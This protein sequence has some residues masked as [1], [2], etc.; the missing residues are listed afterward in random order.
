MGWARSSSGSLEDD[1]VAAM[2][3]L[4]EYSETSPVMERSTMR[5]GD[6]RGGALGTLTA[7][8]NWTVFFCLECALV[9]IFSSCDH[10]LFWPAKEL[11]AKV[12]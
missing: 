9:D 11:V 4:C 10:V 5:L 7:L 3:L 8:W 2:A 6:S 1:G 12:D